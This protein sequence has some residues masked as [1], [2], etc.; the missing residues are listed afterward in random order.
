FQNIPVISPYMGH[1]EYLEPLGKE[2]PVG[3]YTQ[4]YPYM[5]IKDNKHAKFIADYEKRFGEHPK[6]AALF[7]YIAVY[8]IN[9]AIEKARK[10]D[11]ASIRDALEGLKFDTPVGQ[12]EFRAIDHQSTLGA[13]FGKS[14]FMNDTPT[15]KDW[16]YISGPDYMPSDEWIRQNRPSK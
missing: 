15:I 11:P 5:D 14:D 13:W 6:I 4:G 7:S 16:A 1:P 2:A 12:L 9:D 8:A 10:S 3:W